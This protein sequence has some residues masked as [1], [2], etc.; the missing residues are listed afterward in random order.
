M[1]GGVWANGLYASHGG[2]YRT[3]QGPSGPVVLG[4][5][6]GYAIARNVKL[7]DLSTAVRTIDAAKREEQGR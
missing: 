1:G 5:G 4:R 6:T 3:V 2:L 7:A